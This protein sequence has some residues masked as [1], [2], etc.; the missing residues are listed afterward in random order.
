[1]LVELVVR[2]LGVIEEASVVLD[3]GL[4]ALTGE[5]G[6]G[7]TLLTDAL[8]LALGARADA[9]L[10][11]PGADAAE[12]ECRLVVADG[13]ELVIRRVVPAQGRSRAYL[14]GRL[15]SSEALGE[16]TDGLVDLHG[17]HGHQRLMRPSEQRRALDSFGDIDPGPWRAARAARAAADR[18][19]DA[20]GGDEQARAREEDLHR[21]QIT[22]IDEA[23][24]VD[25]DEDRRLAESELLLASAAASRDAAERLAETLS[26]DGAAGEALAGALSE[27][28]QHA[29]LEA[30]ATRLAAVA[31]E[32]A[33][34]GRELRAAAEQ[35]VE[36]PEQLAEMTARRHRLS[37]LRRKY[38]PTLADVLAYRESAAERL[39][40][41][42][43]RTARAAAI[44]AEVERLE[45]EEHRLAGELAAARR[46]AAP[47][48]A[49]AVVDVLGEL[50]MANARFEVSVDG[51][52]GADVEFRLAVNSGAPLASLTKVASGGELSRTMLAVQLVSSVVSP[53]VVFDEVDAGVGGRTATA[54]GRALARLAVDRQV[55]VVTH[56][57]QVAAFADRHLSVTKVDDGT[58]TRTEVASLDDEGRVIELSRMLSGSPDSSTA[59]SHAA[60]LVAAAA[61]ERGSR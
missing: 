4:T 7:K 43:A 29:A 51:E 18:E 14:D 13:D 38:G 50:A 41:L 27:V 9:E 53:T 8:A 2:D 58:H 52:A 48:L 6:A 56:L 37:E 25:L 46:A 44:D 20:L 5:T 3:S 55:L 61:S 32:V 34:L 23:A 47:R 40:E 16:L 39:T 33:D 22:E 30:V 1:M 19:R 54:I 57:P 49:S 31:D 17:Q 11:R 10:V 28:S 21:F 12:V 59:R 42:E 35:I 24:I 26:T 60:E 15:A 36:D 45:A